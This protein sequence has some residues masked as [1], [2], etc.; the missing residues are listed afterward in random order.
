MSLDR[1]QKVIAHSGYTSRRKAEELIVEGK[2]K[3]NGKTV[4]KLGTKVSARDLV[5]I[6]GVPL[7]KE[8]P[9][10]YLLYKPREVISSVEDDRGRTVVTD[11]LP[12][13]NKRIYPIGRL[14]YQSSGIILLTN[15]GEFAHLM[16]HPKHEIDKEYIVKVKGI[17]TKNDLSLMQKGVMNE[18]ELL[19]AVDSR[20]HKVNYEKKTAL[21]KLTLREGRYRHI[22]RMMD[23]LGFPVEKLKRERFGFLDLEGL[24]AGEFREINPKEVRSLRNIALKNVEN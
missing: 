21:L 1:L 18:N 10:Y 12:E 14:D 11:F 4:T 9:V 23:Q 20:I 7:E 6:E 16:M 5:E 13:I 15:D 19:R 22:R 8:A 17:P 2:V 3:V 24:Q